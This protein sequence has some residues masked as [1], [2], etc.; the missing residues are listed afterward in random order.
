MVSAVVRRKRE[1]VITFHGKVSVF[2]AR[3]TP[4]LLDLLIRVFGVKSRRAEATGAVSQ[5]TG[6]G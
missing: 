6:R 5:L 1:A 2:L 4:G 3:H